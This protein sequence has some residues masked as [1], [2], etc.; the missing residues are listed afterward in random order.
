MT[1]ATAGET[2]ASVGH[3]VALPRA[4]WL[5]AITVTGLGALAYGYPALAGQYLASPVSDQYFAGYQ[6]REFARWHVATYGSIPQW[7]PY[8]FGGMPFVDAMHGDTFYPTAALR[9]LIGTAAG[10][11]WGFVI[12]VF[13]AGIFSYAFL[14]SMGLSFAAAL[15]GG[16]AYQMGGNIAGLASPGHDGKL[17]VAAMLPLALWCVVRGV[18]DGRHWA[19]GLLALTVGLAVLSPHPQLLQY[20]L[21][22]TG[23]F[24]LALALGWVGETLPPRRQ[25]LAR[26]GLALGAVA[27]GML[28]G[29]IQ[30]WPVRHY[31]PWSPRAGGTGWETAIT[32]SLPPEEIIN[33]A[34]P[35]FTGIL[36]D[37]WGRNVIHLHSDYIGVVVLI[38]AGLAL[39]KWRSRGLDRLLW[40]FAVT[41]IVSLL[42]ALG[43]NTPFYTLVYYLVPGTKYFR[44]PSTMLFVVTFAAAVLAALGAERVVGL[45]HRKRYLIAVAVV[46][47]L[48]GL[49]GASGGLTDFATGLANPQLVDQ[50]TANDSALRGGALRSMAFGLL[51]CLAIFLATTRRVS[52]DVG[53][54]ALVA[55][56]GIDLWTVVRRYWSFLPSAEAAYAPDEAVKFLQRQPG[57][58]RVIAGDFARSGVYN[59]PNLS[60]DGLMLHRIAVAG[61][62]HG[63]HIGK[64][65]LIGSPNQWAN[66]NFWR[67]AT[68]RYFYST[69][70]DLGLEGATKVMGPVKSA[71][72]S[73]VYLHAL[74]GSSSYAWVAPVI[75]KSDEQSVAATV[76]DPRFDVRS[77]ALFDTSSTA[78]GQQIQAVPAP[79]TISARVTDYRP[80]TATIE[81]DAPAP[82]GSALVVSENF[83]PGWTAKVDGKAADVSR[84]NAAFIGVALPTGARKIELAFVNGPYETGKVVTWFAVGLAILAGVVGAVL[85]RRARARV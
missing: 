33:F 26:L 1:T 3:R 19:W 83:Y 30:F 36:N 46:A 22:V 63:N 53:A 52:R 14:R 38:L 24:T 68:V 10:M 49:L 45:E 51:A 8:L 5:W 66:P 39:G 40:F 59:D 64:Y 65:D 17:F 50:V 6:F 7:N 60:K 35:E 73:D 27:L 11:T 48:I 76:L 84:A 72:G 67:L 82:A 28:I 9:L 18:R 70:P 20:M 42:W 56:V 54:I 74:P 75:V 34:V 29:A 47:V 58:F 31:E 15:L 23:A 57:P 25:G 16:V 2:A 62:Y 12:H 21:L 44:A 78:Q 69:A 71:A 41:F 79:L 43:G 85:D 37:Y 32:Y 55:L 81:L 80:G 13:L 4:A 77:V 61:G